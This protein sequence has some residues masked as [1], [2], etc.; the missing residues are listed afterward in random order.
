MLQDDALTLV[1]ARQKKAVGVLQ[2]LDSTLNT[3]AAQWRSQWGTL[4]Q[5]LLSVAELHDYHKVRF[6]T[7]IPLLSPREGVVGV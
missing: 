5:W 7:F 1:H 3:Q 2:Y 4:G 6:R